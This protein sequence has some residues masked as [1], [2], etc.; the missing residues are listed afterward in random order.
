MDAV[1]DQLLSVLLRA[2]VHWRQMGFGLVLLAMAL[3]M[4]AEIS[5]KSIVLDEIVMIPSA[6]YYVAKRNFELVVEHPP[7]SKFIAAFPLLLLD[8]RTVDFVVTDAT[9]NPALRYSQR[10]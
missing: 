8:L 6:Y 2:P 3:G 7:F 5:K 9:E 10:F 4:L 1:C